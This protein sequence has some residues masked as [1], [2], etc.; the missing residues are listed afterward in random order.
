[1]LFVFTS[2]KEHLVVGVDSPVMK[3]VHDSIWRK[4]EPIRRVVSGS[5][6]P[7][8]PVCFAWRDFQL[9]LP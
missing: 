5:E 6:R 9:L 2:L 7:Y 4:L 8:M 3:P 1:M